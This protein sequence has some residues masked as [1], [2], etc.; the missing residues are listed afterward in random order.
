MGAKIFTLSLSLKKIIDQNATY[1]YMYKNAKTKV[2]VYGFPK[3]EN[4]CKRWVESL[5]NKID[6]PT[7][8][9]SV[10][11]NHWM[12]GFETVRKKGREIPRYPPT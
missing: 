12:E 9:M 1:M 6:K 2:S 4:E 8:Y 10:C 5:P 7:R 11:S 3:D